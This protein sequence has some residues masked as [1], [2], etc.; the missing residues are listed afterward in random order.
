MGS[1]ANMLDSH[2]TYTP[3]DHFETLFNKLL[4][5]VVDKDSVIL[6]AETGFFLE[7]HMIQ[8]QVYIL[9]NSQVVFQA[10]CDC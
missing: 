2:F 9:F 8:G 1:I 5:H 3:P 6:I 7:S 4:A 10:S